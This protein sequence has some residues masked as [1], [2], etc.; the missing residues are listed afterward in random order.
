MMSTSGT[1]VPV[2][3][4][5]AQFRADFP[6][7]SNPAVF[8]DGVIT[9]WLNYAT[10]V[11]PPDRWV[12]LLGTGIELLAAHHIK[13]ET[14]NQRTA[15]VGGV[16][17]TTKG[18]VSGESADGVSVSYEVASSLDQ[19][20]QQ[21]NLTN[22]GT[23]FWTLLRLVGAGPIQIG[24]CPGGSAGIGLQFGPLGGIPFL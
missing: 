6:E 4:T 11:L 8:P 10:L 23:R 19:N 21:Y 18:P 1:P 17:G 5:I 2:P 13:I 16:P 22:Y 7:M 3:V 9:Y 12:T 14:D 15:A 24:T 20:A